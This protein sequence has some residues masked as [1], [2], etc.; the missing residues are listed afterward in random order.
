MAQRVAAADAAERQAAVKRLEAAR[1][2]MATVV[3]G[4]WSVR[5]L[6]LCSSLCKLMSWRTAQRTRSRHAVSAGNAA[7]AEH[8]H[9][10]AQLEG[11]Q[12]RRIAA[13]QLEKDRREQAGP[14]ADSWDL[15][16]A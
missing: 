2:L 1:E 6:V 12:D 7:L 3:A 15:L 16:Q 13:Y 11:E 9:L 4:K 10:Q 5:V 8:K 14:F